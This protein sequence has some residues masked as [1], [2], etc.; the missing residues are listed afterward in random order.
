LALIDKRPGALG[1]HRKKPA[2]VIGAVELREHRE[3]PKVQARL[4]RVAAA[5]AVRREESDS[6]AR[7]VR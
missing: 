1:Q 5:I 3:N 2:P 6:A 4:A 7:S